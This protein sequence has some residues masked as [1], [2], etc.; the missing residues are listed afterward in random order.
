MQNF[1]QWSY[2]NSEEKVAQAV[3]GAYPERAI[4]IWKRL[5]EN[6]IAQ[7]K[8]RAYEQAGVYLTKLRRIL[9]SQGKG[10]EW[11]SYAAGLRSANIRKRRLLEVLDGLAGKRIIET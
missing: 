10:A 5:A 7:T 9:H 6:Q 8:P 4:A 3:A 1:W 11:N 2:F